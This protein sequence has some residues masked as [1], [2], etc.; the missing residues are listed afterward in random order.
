MIRTV[1]FF[2]FCSTGLLTILQTPDLKV[3]LESGVRSR[4][5]G[6]LSFSQEGCKQGL[7]R[8]SL[9]FNK[10]TK[11]AIALEI[12]QAFEAYVR[13]WIDARA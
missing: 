6:E 1:H 10:E 12:H 7:V 13:G 3:G 11:S 2:A 5:E 9:R 8:I 4:F